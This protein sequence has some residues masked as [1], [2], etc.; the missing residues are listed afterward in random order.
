MVNPNELVDLEPEMEDILSVWGKGITARNIKRYFGGSESS[1]SEIL[2][3]KSIEIKLSSLHL[4]KEWEGNVL[5]KHDSPFSQQ[6]RRL[7]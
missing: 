2:L 3:Q 5:K 7:G 4:F 1:R 6:T